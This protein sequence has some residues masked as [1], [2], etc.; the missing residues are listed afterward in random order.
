MAV[1]GIGTLIINEMKKLNTTAIVCLVIILLSMFGIWRTEVKK[2]KGDNT[3]LVEAYRNKEIENSGLKLVVTRYGDSLYQA[4]QTI[5][6]KNQAIEMGILA[7]NEL[8][9]KHLKEVE[10]VIELTEKIEILNKEGKADPVLITIH[11]TVY[12]KLPFD[13]NF[14]DKWYNLSVT[15]REIPLLNSLTVYSAP[16]LTLGKA[17]EGLFK[18][19]E[20]VVI[21]E[22]ANPYISLKDLSCVTIQENQRFLEKTW[23]HIAEGALIGIVFTS[24][25]K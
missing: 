12:A 16:T 22:N 9:A 25:V 5:L 23:V 11:D 8:R 14:S 2:L 10:N 20:R 17:K 4:R 13:M 15:A 6:T 21:Y 7:V 3:N 24:L 18:K 19:P 1:Y